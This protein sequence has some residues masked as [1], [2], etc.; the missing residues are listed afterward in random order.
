LRE[1]F[2][3]EISDQKKFKEMMRDALKRAQ[4][5]YPNAEFDTWGSGITLLPSPPPVQKTQVVISMSH[6]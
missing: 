5:V 3:R 6:R 4:L 2:G 1:Q